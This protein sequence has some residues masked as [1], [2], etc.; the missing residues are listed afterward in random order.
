ERVAPIC[1]GV[2]VSS[3]VL[4]VGHSAGGMAAFDS[5]GEW[6]GA[7]GGLRGIA[8]YGSNAPRSVTTNPN[9]P[10]VMLMC[11][12]EDSFVT[13][14]IARRAFHG[15]SWRPKALIEMPELDHFAIVDSGVGDRYQ[16]GRHAG[17]GVR[18]ADRIDRISQ[19][20]TAF[21]ESLTADS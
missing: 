16:T 3:G 9:G 19:A 4:L 6:P 8:V 14:E 1:A 7:T 10:P 18:E 2:V 11:G 21:F 13:V 12:R 15:I 5:V 20:I 17:P